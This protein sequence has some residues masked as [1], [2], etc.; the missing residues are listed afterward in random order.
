MTLFSDT[1]HG[2][3][4]TFAQLVGDH[5]EGRLTI[6]HTCCIKGVQRQICGHQDPLKT[7]YSAHQEHTRSCCF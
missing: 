7:K 2:V 1:T 4:A 6:Y 3:G 5:Q